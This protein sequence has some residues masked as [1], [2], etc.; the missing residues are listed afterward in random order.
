MDRLGVFS[1]RSLDIDVLLDLLIHDLNLVL[2]LLQ[3]KIVDVRALGVPVVTGKVDMA[4]VWLELENGA[5]ASLTASRV[6]QDPSRKQRF[7]GTDFYVSVDTHK[8]EVR[9]SRLVREDGKS[10]LQPFELTVEPKEPLRAENEAFLQCVR[11]RSRPIVSGEDGLE[12]VAL[13][14]RVREAIDAQ[15]KRFRS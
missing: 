1:G 10:T 7:F 8:R 5:V 11:D 15:E 9:G 14:D 12:A 3:Q 13:A 6:S 4:K 2:S